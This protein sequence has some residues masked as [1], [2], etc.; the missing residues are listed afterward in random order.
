ML[1]ISVGVL[2]PPNKPRVEEEQPA[3]IWVVAED[4]KSPK[5]IAFPVV[6]IVI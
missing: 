3:I 4:I 2:P 6:E 1:F 5:S